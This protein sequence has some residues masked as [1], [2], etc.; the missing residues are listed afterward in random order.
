MVH[1]LIIGFPG[2]QVQ[3][4]IGSDRI[5]SDKCPMRLLNV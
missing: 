2:K 1:L 3:I 4:A 5:Y